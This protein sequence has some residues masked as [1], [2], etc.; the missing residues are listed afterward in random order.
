VGLSISRLHK[1]TLTPAQIDPA[2]IYQPD[3]IADGAVSFPAR[4]PGDEVILMDNGDGNH[5]VYWLGEDGNYISPNNDFVVFEKTAN[6]FR[7]TTR[8]GMVK[9]FDNSGLLTEYRDRNGNTTT[10]AYD[11]LDRLISV[12]DP[13]G[14][15]TNLSYIGELLKTITDPA[16]RETRL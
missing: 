6:G 2:T 11:N 8:S 9:E 5:F 7:R 4:E 12:T 13:V 16:G 15:V 14:L 10:Y 3:T 1:T